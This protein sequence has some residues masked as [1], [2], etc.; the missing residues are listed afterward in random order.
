MKLGIIGLPN[1]GK[2]TLFNA[3]TRQ[4]LEAT[5][6][7]NPASAKAPVGVIKVPDQRVDRLSAIFNPKKTTYAEVRCVDVT[8][9]DRGISSSSQKRSLF[10][11]AWDTDALIHI[12]RAFVN[13]SVVHD[14]E[15]DPLAD[16]AALDLELVFHDLELVETRLERIENSIKKGIGEGLD[17]EKQVLERCREALE[18]GEPLRRLAFSAGERAAIGSLQF[19]SLKPV[20]VVLNV[21]EDAIAGEATTQ[22]VAALS[23]YYAGTEEL[24]FSLSCKIEMEI[25]QLPPDDAALFLEELCITEPAMNL[26]I[27]EAYELLG[28]IS[29]FTVGEDEVR[30]WTTRQGDRAPRAAGRVHSDIERGFIRAETIG[31]DDFIEAGDMARARELGTLRSEGKDYVVRDG[32]IFNFRF[33][34]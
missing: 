14:G 21:S 26:V 15:I 25:S 8:G 3:L 11:L 20:L 5:S 31:Y 34:V 18:R 19:A 30:A 7:P 12:V 1:A 24:A 22:V 6:Y 13:D 10:E 29:F 9:F 4:A 17:V 23:E 27:R 32:D 28:L 16:A 33:N 2:T